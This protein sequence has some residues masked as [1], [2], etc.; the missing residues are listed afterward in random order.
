[1]FGSFHGKMAISPL[2]TT[3][4][5]DFWYSNRYCQHFHHAKNTVGGLCVGGVSI[6]PGNLHHYWCKLTD[7]QPGNL[8]LTQKRYSQTEILKNSRKSYKIL[9]NLRKFQKILGNPRKSLKIV[10]NPSNSLKVLKKHN[11][12]WG[13]DNP[14]KERIL[15]AIFFFQKIF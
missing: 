5:L 6:Q 1:M 4:V 14:Q 7:R 9:G 2:H 13:F 3:H 15:E 11:F 10:E 12:K 8:P